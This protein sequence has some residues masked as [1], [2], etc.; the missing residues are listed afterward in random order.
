VV[1]SDIQHRLNQGAFRE[2]PDFAGD[3]QSM[4]AAIHQSAAE[5]RQQ[6]ISSGLF[7]M[8]WWQWRTQQLDLDLERYVRLLVSYANIAMLDENARTAFSDE[9]RRELAAIPVARV[10]V[11]NHIYAVVARAMR[12]DGSWRHPLVN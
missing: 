3:E 10:P 2:H 6:L 1:R 11:T 4:L 9:L 12:R 8:P 7:G 5:G